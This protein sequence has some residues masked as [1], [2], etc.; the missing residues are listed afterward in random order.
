MANSIGDRSKPFPGERINS[1]PR[2]TARSVATTIEQPAGPQ[3]TA[4][5][6]DDRCRRLHD[7]VAGPFDAYRIGRLETPV[8]LYDLSLGGCFVNSFHE[9]QEGAP[10]TL[11]IDLPQEGWITV[12][13]E[14]LYR[15]PGFGFAVRFVNMDAETESCLERT[16]QLLKERQSKI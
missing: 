12:N 11:K 4:A 2:E 6:N 16:I 9:Q 5:E 7:R 10:I 15:R 13:A 8:R 1:V 14:T 3:T